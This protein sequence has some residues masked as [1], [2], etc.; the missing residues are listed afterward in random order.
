[1]FYPTAYRPDL[2][3]AATGS[4]PRPAIFREAM[5]F[6]AIMGKLLVLLLP[7]LPEGRKKER[8][9]RTEKGKENEQGK[10]QRGS[11]GPVFPRFHA[12]SACPT[13]FFPPVDQHLSDRVFSNPSQRKAPAA[14]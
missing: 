12:T 11:D 1:M 9:G 6:P 7:S 10:G 8:G 14:V 5:L 3:M 13:R 4:R 2:I